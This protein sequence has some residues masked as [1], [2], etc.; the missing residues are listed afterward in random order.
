MS[1]GRSWACW[2]EIWFAAYIPTSSAKISV[3]HPSWSHVSGLFMTVDKPVPGRSAVEMHYFVSLFRIFSRSVIGN[4][5]S[6]ACRGK[7]SNSP[8]M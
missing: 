1:L 3:L 8:P 5:L 7:F 2:S 6:A 4:G